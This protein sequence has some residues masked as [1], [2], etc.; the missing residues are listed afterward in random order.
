LIDPKSLNLTKKLIRGNEPD[1]MVSLK[2]LPSCK[3]DDNS[4]R[5]SLEWINPQISH[6]SENLFTKNDIK[7]NN[8][9]NLTKKLEEINDPT[10]LTLRVSRKISSEHEKNKM[11]ETTQKETQTQTQAEAEVE[12]PL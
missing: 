8:S 3:P 10:N 12:K 1:K 4:R 9:I 7:I 11:L 5:P 2:R 6:E